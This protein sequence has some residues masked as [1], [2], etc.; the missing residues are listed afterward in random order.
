MS[1]SLGDC[2]LINVRTEQK[3]C[4]SCYVPLSAIMSATQQKL[5]LG[6]SIVR[7]PH[8]T[9]TGKLFIMDCVCVFVHLRWRK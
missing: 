3:Y 2:W 4:K 5:K 7:I 6:T 1:E 8:W 9:V